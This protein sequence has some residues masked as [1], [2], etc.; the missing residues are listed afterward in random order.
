[1]YFNSFMRAKYKTGDNMLLICIFLIITA[2]IINAMVVSI[3][4]TFYKIK[5]NSLLDNINTKEDLLYMNIKDFEN[6]IAVM[7]KRNGYKVEFTERFGEGN[8]GLILNN[9]QYVQMEKSAL[10]RLMDVEP[11]R[12]LSKSMQTDSIYRGIIITLGGYK[13]I[14]RNYCHKN[15]IK[16]IDG[17]QL[18][19]MLR[20]SK[21]KELRTKEGVKGILPRP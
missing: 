17:D 5:I 20:D 14:T 10:N 19:N 16:C 21:N 2:L 18:V 9:L 7:F 1:M 6:I 8:R 3:A 15:V 13:R 11:V 4:K 12:K